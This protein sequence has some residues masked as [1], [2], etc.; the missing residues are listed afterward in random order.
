MEFS[1]AQGIIPG[2]R[3]EL[4]D[5]ARTSKVGTKNEQPRYPCNIDISVTKQMLSG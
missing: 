4:T 1:P 5:E 3:I 2:I